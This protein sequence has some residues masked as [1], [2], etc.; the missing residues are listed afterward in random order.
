MH[1]V[2]PLVYGIR[3]AERGSV[4]AVDLRTVTYVDGGY[5]GGDAIMLYGDF[6][7]KAKLGPVATLG[8]SGER[9]VFVDTM[10]S[11]IVLDESGAQV[12][13]F[14]AGVGDKSVE[15][16]SP[17]FSTNTPGYS[18]GAAVAAEYPSSKLCS[19]DNALALI[20]ASFKEV[21]FFVKA[22][23]GT[24][25]RL[26]GAFSSLYGVFYDV[27]SPLYNGDIAA[28]VTAASDAG[29]GAV[30]LPPGASTLSELLI[31]PSTVS[32]IG[33]GEGASLVIVTAGAGFIYTESLSGK[34]CRLQDFTIAT[35]ELF[36]NGPCVTFQAG[37]RVNCVN[38]GIWPGSGIAGGVLFQDT[39]DIATYVN[40]TG[41]DF[42]V[43]Y[44]SSYAI[45][46]VSV[47]PASRMNVRRSQLRGNISG[48]MM[49]GANIHF[50]SFDFES[51][52]SS[53]SN[54]Q[55]SRAGAP[56]LK[57]SFVGCRFP[58]ENVG[59]QYSPFDAGAVV[60]G[61]LFIEHGSLCA[62]SL[63]A[64]NDRRYGLAFSGNPDA[65]YLHV[66]SDSTK[67]VPI[68][69]AT[70]SSPSAEFLAN[71][72]FDLKVTGTGTTGVLEFSLEAT[73]IEPAVPGRTGFVT[74]YIKDDADI[75]GSYFGQGISSSKG[76]RLSH[77]TAQAGGMVVRKCKVNGK[78][79]W[80]P[81]S[82][83]GPSPGTQDF[84]QTGINILYQRIGYGA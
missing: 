61:D 65:G 47:N 25:K 29:G 77:G 2:D 23:D 53:L 50:D 16:F 76:I 44:S 52:S 28:A 57:N 43:S 17:A 9:D 24:S 48:P 14:I 67:T 75:L 11:F 22:F 39:A 56:S 49:Q 60:S 54:F 51:W 58:I 63:D 59:T 79:G 37:A 84:S 1:R 41:C 69:V 45:S 35:D 27:G 70:G 71:R 3:G 46:S 13:Q 66:C 83:S 81:T 80:Y 55:Y 7:G 10:A 21:D 40:M 8:D 42:F 32:I 64:V 19:L 5:S 38:V 36:L 4:S 31:V 12:R 26:V 78:Y 30:L 18:P 6:E 72:I 62:N 33:E 68:S 82:A 20:L 15:L 34:A 73:E 74:I